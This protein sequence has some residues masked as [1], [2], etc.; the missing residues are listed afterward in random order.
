MPRFN[1]G[2]AGAEIAGTCRLGQ[3]NL[4]IQQGGVGRTQRGGAATKSNRRLPQNTRNTRKAACC[5]RTRNSPENARFWDIP[6]IYTSD[7][8]WL[9]ARQL[10]SVTRSY[11]GLP[12]PSRTYRRPTGAC[13]EATVGKAREKIQHPKTKLQ[14]R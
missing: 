8:H 14:G 12:A 5:I 2:I 3:S 1:C 7:S 10:Q 9:H 11:Q 13:R 6:E 4:S